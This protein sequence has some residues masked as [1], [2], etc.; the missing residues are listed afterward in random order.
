[1]HNIVQLMDGHHNTGCTFNFLLIYIWQDYLIY[2]TLWETFVLL[3]MIKSAG[4]WSVTNDNIS[5]TF[6]NNTW[7][8]EKSLAEVG[9]YRVSALF[10]LY[11]VQ[12][13]KDPLVQKIMVGMHWWILLWTLDLDCNLI[14]SKLKETP[15]LER[16]FLTQITKKS[17]FHT[18]VVLF[19]AINKVTFD[20]YKHCASK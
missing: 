12:D 13:V 11:V 6:N 1:M 5:G 18:P 20:S 7:N 15:Q 9:R 2:L 14:T 17:F 3:Q 4:S 19:F 8:L 10:S 16:W